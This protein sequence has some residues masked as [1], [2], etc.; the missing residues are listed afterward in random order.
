MTIERGEL[1]RQLCD[2]FMNGSAPRYIFGRTPYAA[3]IARHIKPDGIID[4]F[5]TE[6]SFNQIPVIKL[7]AVPI[8]AIIVSSIVD[9]RPITVNRLLEKTGIRNIDYYSFK[10]YSGLPLTEHSLIAPSEFRLNYQQ[11][12]EK[13]DHI[14]HLLADECSK[15]TFSRLV[16]FRLNENLDEM[17]YFTFRPEESYF[18]PFI[19]L[20][21]RD[22]VFVDVGSFDGGTT[23]EFI[24]RYP[25]YRSVHLFEPEPKQMSVIRGKVSGFN[26]I[27]YHECGASNCAG[28]LKFTSSGSWSHVDEAGDIEVK[29][30]TIDAL[31]NEKTSFIKMDIE[32]H[33]YA[34]LEGAREHICQDHPVLAICAYH[35][36]DDFWKLPELILSYRSDYK[37]Y[38]R[39][40]TEGVLETV[41]YFIP[42][43]KG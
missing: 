23:L 7:A 43:K 10:R 16:N 39:H 19:S 35:L 4:D 26:N 13:F 28:V 25:A 9:G 22:A 14:Y 37:L 2:E 8:D 17:T 3:D 33:E 42:Q 12:R 31:V 41:Y 40:Y 15:E 38:M 5:T 6:T 20:N 18:E 30:N 1:N 27:H 34:A 11:Y 29:I 36:V 32:G 21:A 24:R